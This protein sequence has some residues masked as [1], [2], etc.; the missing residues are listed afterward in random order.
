M[1]LCQEH[2]KSA[3]RVQDAAANDASR[4][5]RLVA[6]PGTGKSKVIEKRL[7]WLLDKDVPPRQIFVTSFTRTSSIDLQNRVR[8]Y[9][10]K[11][12]RSLKDAIRVSTLHSLALSILRRAKEL[13]RYPVS[14][15]VLDEWEI[16]RI[17]DAEFNNIAGHT[18][19]RCDDIRRAYEAYWNTDQHQ[20][21]NYI[22]PDPP[23]S[24]K[25]RA[26]FEAFH[27]TITHCYAC[28]LPGEIV[29]ECVR[30]IRSGTLDPVNILDLK[31]L[32]V[33]EFQD[34][35]PMDLMFVNS[36]INHGAN[37]FVAGDDDQ[38]IY[39][40]RFAQPYG[41]QE[42]AERHSDCE[43]HTLTKCFRCTPHILKRA[44]AVISKNSPQTRIEKDLISLYESADPALTGIV[45]HWKFDSGVMEARAV[46]RSCRDLIASGVEPRHILILISN[47]KDLL[48]MLKQEFE[49][50]K[51]DFESPNEDDFR[52][53][54]LGRFILA[55]MRI[56][57]DGNDYVA[58]RTL[59]QS[60]KGVGIQ[61]CVDITNAVVKGNLNYL[62]IF[63][64]ELLP[65]VF[66][67]RSSNALYKSRTVCEEI[68]NW[69]KD[70]ELA[71]FKSAIASLIESN[72]ESDDLNTWN[73]YT[74]QFP[75]KM[76]LSE[77]RDYLGTDDNVRRLA[78]LQEVHSRLGVATT[79][80]A[81]SSRV[82]IMTMHGAK[83]LSA[84]I[85]FIPGLEEE[86]FPG[87]RRRL[88]AGMVQEAARLMYVSLTRARASYIASYAI[89]RIVHGDFSNK[90]TP[91]SFV[92]DLGQP[93]VWRNDGLNPKE[94]ECIIDQISHL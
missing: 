11:H 5:I 84:N 75:N 56:V 18:L 15:L 41:I 89:T 47:K 54:D 29:R 94:V 50:L 9:L 74:Q 21:A 71:R 51:V 79:S 69:S 33:D 81:D 43:S 45:H 31:H 6:G 62:Q 58:H 61:T 57:C 38:S 67:G 83:G 39:S 78:I 52:D 63:Y 40:F 37:V 85:V 91:S 70:E 46:A 60:F 92:K 73:E 59:L 82:R 4:H 22:A 68:K 48:P 20:P 16:D 86:I 65:P 36:M 90:R 32:I 19:P 10:S 13:S 77:L 42:F 3:E 53:S 12:G 64:D 7:G 49:N 34:L 55:I 24:H 87:P 72:F 80:G 66:S 35:N 2:V 26:D 1:A 14:P 23:I 17:F 8:A 30:S 88:R 28:V 93:F 27:R 25:E 76:T 44:H